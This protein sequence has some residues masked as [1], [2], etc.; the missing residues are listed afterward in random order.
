MLH[1]SNPDLLSR[2]QLIARVDSLEAELEALREANKPADTLCVQRAFGL[3]THEAKLL[4]LL[5]DGRPR[6]KEQIHSGIYADRIDDPPEMK[7]IDVFVCKTRKKVEPYGIVV[8]TIWG[9]GYQLS[10]PVDVIKSV[11]AGGN[12]T[13]IRSAEPRQPP[14]HLEKRK[15]Y[16]DFNAAWADIIAMSNGTTRPV[17]FTSR[18]MASRA[19]VHRNVATLLRWLEQKGKIRIIAAPPPGGRNLHRSWTVKLTHAA[20]TPSKTENAA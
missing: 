2:A 4:L 3:T 18:E 10:D 14:P 13:V 17:S 15:A 12:P 8:E 5:S 16:E 11:I 6:R 20:A 7:I 1:Q 9:S 19:G